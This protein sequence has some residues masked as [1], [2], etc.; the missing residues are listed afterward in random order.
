MSK[1]IANRLIPC[2]LVLALALMFC[3]YDGAGAIP[4]AEEFLIGEGTI[5]GGI[6]LEFEAAPP[7]EIIPRAQNL[8]KDDAEFHM[9]VLARFVEGNQFNAPAGGFVPYLNVFLDVVNEIT[10][11]TTHLMLIPHNTLGGDSFHYARNVNLPGDPAYDSYTFIYF[12]A[13]PDKFDLALHADFIREFGRRFFD[14]IK[15]EFNGVKLN[16]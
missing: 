1:Y 16:S 7:D 6:E 11:E 3:Y 10:G 14:P 13:P 9:E 5:P 2:L 4:G 12:V 15:F 8:S